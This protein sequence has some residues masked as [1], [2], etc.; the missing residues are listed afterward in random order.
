M[1]RPRKKRNICTMPHCTSFSPKTGD[2][3]KVIEMTVDEFET[4]RLIDLEELTQEQ[5]ALQMGVARTTVQAI[6]RKARLKIAESI[7]HGKSLIIGGGDFRV[8][9][10][11]DDCCGKRRSFKN[12]E[13]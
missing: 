4:I 13:V 9:G 7:V 12:N 1:A 8:R 3:G 10:H 11:S 5:C 6:Y 2:H